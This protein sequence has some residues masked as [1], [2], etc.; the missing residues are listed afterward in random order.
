MCISSISLG[1]I[2]ACSLLGCPSLYHSMSLMLL[3]PVGTACM[4]ALYMVNLNYITI[5]GDE[6]F[7]KGVRAIAETILAGIVLCFKTGL[8]YLTS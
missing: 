3:A 5:F 2:K 8:S 4:I 7:S 1:C 6:L